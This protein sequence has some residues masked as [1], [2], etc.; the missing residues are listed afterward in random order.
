[1]VTYYKLIPYNGIFSRGGSIFMDRQ[2]FHSSNLWMHEIVPM[3]ASVLPKNNLRHDGRG[4]ACGHIKAFGLFPF[5]HQ[6][7]SVLKACRADMS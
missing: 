2:T 5:P 3:H 6:R 7:K 4:V 1:M